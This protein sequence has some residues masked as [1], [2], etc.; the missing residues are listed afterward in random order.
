MLDLNNI[1]KSVV[2]NVLGSSGHGLILQILSSPLACLC[3]CPSYTHRR[4]PS[5]TLYQPKCKLLIAHRSDRE[6]DRVG[7]SLPF[8]SKNLA[9]HFDRVCP[10]PSAC[11]TNFFKLPSTSGLAAAVPLFGV[12]NPSVQY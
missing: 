10:F 4:A 1:L 8:V 11:D 5:L 3:L 7:R 6:C 2:N 9:C 12:P